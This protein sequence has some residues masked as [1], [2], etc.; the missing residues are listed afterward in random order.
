MAHTC[1]GGSGSPS[2]A[3]SLCSS[4]VETNCSI[5]STP[6]VKEKCVLRNSLFRH[7]FCCS[8]TRRRDSSARRTI[9]SRSSSETR[10]SGSGKS[11]FTSPEQVLC[12][13]STSRP[14]RAPPQNTRFWS[15]E[16]RL[17]CRR[18]VQHS[19]R[20]S[21]TSPKWSG[22]VIGRAQ[23]REV[24]A[25]RIGVDAVMERGVVPHLLRQRTQEMADRCCCSTS[26]SKFPTMT[27]PP[28]ARMLSLPRL[29]S[30]E[31]M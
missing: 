18:R 22:Q 14:L 2:M 29:N 24:P 8:F 21:L 31:A 16:T 28:S 7:R 6:N 15:T 23:L 1:P 25:G 27:T 9:H 17:S 12:T 19:L 5:P 20:K 3:S 10:S 4:G 13:A 30:P 11:S 26:T